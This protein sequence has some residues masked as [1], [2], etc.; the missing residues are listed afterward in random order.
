MDKMEAEN[1]EMVDVVDKSNRVIGE[2]PRK[3]VHKT[4]KLHRAVHIFM[5]DSNGR[6]W[7]ERRGQSVDT[8]PGFYDSSAAGHVSKGE[9]YDAAAYRE[10]VEELGIEGL[11]LRPSYDLPL[12]PDTKNEFVRLYV[13][14]SDKKPRL[15]EDAGSQELYTIEEIDM[16]IK[17]REKFVPAFLLLFDW[18]K[19]NKRTIEA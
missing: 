1:V 17:N 7:I 19:R 14:R 16:K 6:L 9:S 11:D 15:H 12:G 2:T 5:L 3:G 13:T 8:H 4:D 10:A 18:Y